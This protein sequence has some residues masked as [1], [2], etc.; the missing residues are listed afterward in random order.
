MATS[1]VARSLMAEA[2]GFQRPCIGKRVASV[3]ADMSPSGSP[4]ANRYGWR[5]LRY[6]PGRS[7][8]EA[9]VHDVY[10]KPV[11]SPAPHVR[12]GDGGGPVHLLRARGRCPDRP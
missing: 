5:S 7:C 2:P 8:W 10:G 1:S 4:L 12:G 6:D 9:R 3:N 11:V